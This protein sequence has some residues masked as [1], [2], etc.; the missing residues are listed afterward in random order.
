MAVDLA[1]DRVV[2]VEGIREFADDGDVVRVGAIGRVILV[3]HSFEE[4]LE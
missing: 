1:L 4:S 2:S 3:C